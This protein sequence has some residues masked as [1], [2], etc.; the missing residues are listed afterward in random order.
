M[1]K[2][3]LFESALCDGKTIYIGRN[4]NGVVLVCSSDLSIVTDFLSSYFKND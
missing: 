3:V 4:Q 1:S 2:V